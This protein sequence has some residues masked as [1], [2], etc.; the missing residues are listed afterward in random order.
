MTKIFLSVL[1]CLTFNLSFA[2]SQ[3]EMN[4]DAQS[5]YKKAETEINSV[6]QQILKQYSSDQVFIKNLRT[7]QKL[8]IQFRDAEMKAKFPDRTSGY[9]GSVQPTCWN[10]Y[11]TELTEE[12]INKLRIWLTGIE[13]GDVCNGSVK[14]KR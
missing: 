5:K 13:E 12:R 2:Q 3:A 4:Q 6:Y 7:A 9:Y 11:L 14:I 8:W 1:F 10:M